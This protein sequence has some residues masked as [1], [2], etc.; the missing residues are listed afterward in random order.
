MA[1]KS[2]G[3]KT[4]LPRSLAHKLLLANLGLCDRLIE[5]SR[6]AA[7]AASRK[8][9]RFFN[10]LVEEG[11][12][13]ESDVLH[14][15]E[16][17]ESFAFSEA[18][19]VVMGRHFDKARDRFAARVEHVVED[20]VEDVREAAEGAGLT[21]RAIARTAK[22]VLHDIAGDDLTRIK[23]IGPKREADLHAE[24]I[25][26]YEQLAFLSGK[27]M[28]SLDEKIGL[29]G[30]ARVKKWCSEAKKLAAET[31]AA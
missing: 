12:E 16:E 25:R 2:T 27:E 20:A 4:Q 5:D 7:N 24:G 10:W 21:R 15:L 18:H 26:T 23:G 14:R 19:I 17:N 8:A 31:A 30:K 28:T 13:I 6:S 22:R 9:S 1:A 11:E 29:G 3:R